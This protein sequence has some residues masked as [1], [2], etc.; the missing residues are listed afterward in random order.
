MA[1]SE[2]GSRKAAFSFLDVQAN[3]PLPGL[4]ASAANRIPRWLLVLIVVLYIGHGLFHR[5]P[6]RGE[7]MLGLALARTAAEALLRGDVSLL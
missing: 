5:D 3:A 6:W 4:A 1:N 2:K 7:D